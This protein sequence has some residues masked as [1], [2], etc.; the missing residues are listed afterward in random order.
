MCLRLLHR[1][2]VA[3]RNQNTRKAN[4]SEYHRSSNCVTATRTRLF[5]TC[6]FM[7]FLRR[8]T[9]SIARRYLVAS[10]LSRPIIATEGSSVCYWRRL[11]NWPSAFADES[12]QQTA[13]LVILDHRLVEIVQITV[14]LFILAHA[15]NSSYRLWRGA[16]TQC[17]SYGCDLVRFVGPPGS[18]LSCPA[19]PRSSI[20]IQITTD[21]ICCELLMLLLGWTWR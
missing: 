6:I 19:S 12:S 3:D 18:R 2:T 17:R 11:T 4:S 20:I 9:P 8:P 10:F 16:A 21:D 15:W 5:M 1:C 13:A 7:S 14:I